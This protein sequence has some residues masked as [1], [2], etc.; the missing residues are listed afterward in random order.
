MPSP[1]AVTS[2]LHLQIKNFPALAN[3]PVEKNSTDVS[4]LGATGRLVIV[5]HGDPGQGEGVL[6]GFRCKFY[7]HVLDIE[8]YVAAETDQE[9]DALFESLC[10]DV[11]AALESDIT[12]GGLVQGLDYDAVAPVPEHIEGAANIV[13][14]VLGV[15]TEYQTG[16]PAS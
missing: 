5:R 6:G 10:I 3:D 16:T 15:N 9:R 14:A 11:Y 7:S 4:L 1:F 8:M 13:S 12:L 2:A